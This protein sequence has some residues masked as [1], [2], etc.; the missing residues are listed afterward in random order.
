MNKFI[1]KKALENFFIED[2]GER[3]LSTTIFPDELVTTGKFIAKSDG[4]ICGFPILLEAYKMFEEDVKV[5]LLINEGSFVKSGTVI[6]SVIG[7]I[8]VLLAA[9]R[10]VLNLLQRMSGIATQTNFAILA[11]NSEHTRVC[12]TR[13]TMPGLRIF[14]KYAVRCGGGFNH[15]SG[16]YDTVMLKD[17]HVAFAGSIKSAVET[18]RN[19]LGHT[20]K[21]EV[22]TENIDQVIE[23]ID[24]KADIIMFDNATP[25][26]VKEYCAL[27]P[28][29]IITEA[30]GGITL[31][32]ISMYSD[33]GVDYISLGMLTHSVKALDISFNIEGSFKRR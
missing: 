19:T 11:L 15:R 8:K 32:N 6:A 5:E 12:D 7:P 28:S 4:I 10:V 9:E 25:S 24:S 18:L 14:D 22:E 31:E 26:E 30:S 1:V 27:V 20:V 21:I 33:T 29:T 13:K 16:L 17:N 2:I 3:D 23:A